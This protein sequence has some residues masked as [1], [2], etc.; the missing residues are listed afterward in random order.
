MR[1][2]VATS[3][4]IRDVRRWRELVALRSS[5]SWPIHRWGAVRTTTV[6]HARALTVPWRRSHAVHIRSTWAHADG[7]LLL[8]LHLV[9]L[10]H[11]VLLLQRH[12]GLA[13]VAPTA[14]VE[15]VRSFV[16]RQTTE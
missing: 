9:H 7:H 1:S 11:L 8:V 6:R 5:R 13:D 16:L 2:P 3:A 12:L 15:F 14:L 4:G 10:L